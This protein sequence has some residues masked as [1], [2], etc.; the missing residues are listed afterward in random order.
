MRPI[1]KR[2]K[3]RVN[4]SLLLNAGQD[5]GVKKVRNI[6]EAGY[7]VFGLQ[8]K[9][10]QPK[11]ALVFYSEIDRLLRKTLELPK[12]PTNRYGC[13]C[14]P[15][16]RSVLTDT[17]DVSTFSG[18]MVETHIGVIL[19]DEKNAVTSLDTGQLKVS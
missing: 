13:A 16:A 18:K 17:I 4:S 9:T 8:L 11:S 15:Q 19:E 5:S 2:A 12:P 14:I 6:C 1:G 10:I 3:G 7:A